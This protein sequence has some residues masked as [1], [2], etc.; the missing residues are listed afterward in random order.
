MDLRR[1]EGGG[2]VLAGHVSGRISPPDI[3]PYALIIQF[4]WEPIENYFD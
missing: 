3:P 2:G 1:G 4:L